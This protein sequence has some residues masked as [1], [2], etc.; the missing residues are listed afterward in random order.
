MTTLNQDNN[1]EEGKMMKTENICK[2]SP[3]KGERRINQDLMFSIQ[4]LPKRDDYYAVDWGYVKGKWT[5]S[6]KELYQIRWFFEDN[7]DEHA[8][9]AVL[10]TFGL[11]KQNFTLENVVKMS[12]RE[13]AR[14]GTL[15]PLSN[16]LGDYRYASEV[17]D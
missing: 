14:V 7:F 5:T 10:E 4:Y 6:N 9:E 2:L 12:P 13:L 15:N 3:I 17:Q 1:L 11:F 8:Y 16:T